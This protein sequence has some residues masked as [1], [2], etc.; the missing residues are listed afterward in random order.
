MD[1]DAI[2]R[3]SI[4]AAEAARYDDDHIEPYVNLRR[5]SRDPAIVEVTFPPNARLAVHS[6]PS[7]TLYVF[8]SGEFHIE[9]E[10]VFRPGE[11]RWVRGGEVY[12]PEWAGAEGAVL[13]IVA[14]G[15]PF[16]TTWADGDG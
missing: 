6:H 5:V 13:L 9:G 1:D 3:F 12:G 14:L 7:D 16:G 10:G 11:L 4:D 15:G 8:R 2:R